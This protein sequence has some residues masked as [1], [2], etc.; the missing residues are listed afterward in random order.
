MFPNSSTGFGGLSSARFVRSR[1]YWVFRSA[2]SDF[3]SFANL[4][5]SLIFFQNINITWIYFK[6]FTNYVYAIVYFDLNV[7]IYTFESKKYIW[8]NKR[9]V[10]VLKSTTI[11]Y[12]SY[13]YFISHFA[14]PNIQLDERIKKRVFVFQLA[15]LPASLKCSRCVLKKYFEYYFRQVK[16]GIEGTCVCS[17]IGFSFWLASTVDGRRK[18]RNPIKRWL[19]NSEIWR[20]FN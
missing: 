16:T 8:L 11:F 3:S 5:R 6:R 7:W 20:F 1:N 2:T 14:P 13:W 9:S 18:N 12:E 4:S 17:F 10:I 19:F 15:A